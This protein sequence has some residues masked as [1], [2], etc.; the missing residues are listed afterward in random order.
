MSSQNSPIARMW[1]ELQAKTGQRL[2]VQ[3]ARAQ[4]RV[5][6]IAAEDILNGEQRAVLPDQTI[7][8]LRNARYEAN[9]RA[10]MWNRRII[11]IDAEIADLQR[12][13]EELENV[14]K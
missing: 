10:A 12:Q 8:I 3:N 5:L 13:L 11:E 6:A 7:E 4:W 14:L 2:A 1:E 9:H